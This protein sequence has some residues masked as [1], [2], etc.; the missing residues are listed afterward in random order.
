MTQPRTAD[1]HPD[2]LEYGVSS[3]IARWTSRGASVG[4]VIVTDGEAGIDAMS[5]TRPGRCVE[6]S[7]WARPQRLA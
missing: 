4:Y 3:A 5:P 6:R 7:S 1:Q 2:D